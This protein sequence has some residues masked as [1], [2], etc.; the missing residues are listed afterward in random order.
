MAF[1][2]EMVKFSLYILFPVGILYLYN[3]Q[4]FLSHLPTA[5]ATN[6]ESFKTDPEKLFV[7]DFVLSINLFNCIIIALIAVIDCICTKE[8]TS[9]N[10]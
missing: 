1:G 4:A 8:T 7:S 5:Q 6:M 10:D 2:L 9:L 3:E